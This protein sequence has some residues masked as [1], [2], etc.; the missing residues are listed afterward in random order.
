MAEEQQPV[1]R[2]FSWSYLIS[3]LLIAG[4]IITVIVLLFN[5]NGAK[6]FSQTEFLAQLG[7][8]NITEVRETPKEGTIVNLNGTYKYTTNSGK[9][10]YKSYTFN[11]SYH[12]LYENEDP[13]TYVDASNA[14][15]YLIDDS[16]V[17]EVSES[18]IPSKAITL[19]SFMSKKAALAATEEKPSFVLHSKLRK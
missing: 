16:L 11:I 18:D 15:R 3:F 2:R 10:A 17:S 7:Q 9:T 19:Y 6:E 1:R 8:N 4:I 5:R 13:W 14:Q 12:E